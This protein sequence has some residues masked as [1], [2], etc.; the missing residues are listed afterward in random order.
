MGFSPAEPLLAAASAASSYLSERVGA[1]SSGGERGEKI[2][3]RNKNLQKLS[4]VLGVALQRI[5]CR[6]FALQI[7]VC[8]RQD[9]GGTF[10]RRTFESRARR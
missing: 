3:D 10:G 8:E 2:N 9:T 4:H 5:V 6:H 7:R 1:K